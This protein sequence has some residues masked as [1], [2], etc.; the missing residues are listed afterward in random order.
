MAR[1]DVRNGEK[2][3]HRKLDLYLYQKSSAQPIDDATVRLSGEMRYMSHGDFVSA[4]LKSQGGHYIFLLPF[5]MDGEWQVDLD[6]GVSGKQTKM[7]L[8]V[9]LYQ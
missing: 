5:A 8:E 1:L 9:D 3:F 4:P 2:R 6:I 7:K